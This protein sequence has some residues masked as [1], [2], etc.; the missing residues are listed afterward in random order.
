MEN[1]RKKNIA[2]HD[3]IDLMNAIKAKGEELRELIASIH[4]VVVPKLPPIEA[5]ASDTSD[6]IALTVNSDEWDP[7][8]EADYPTYWL[9]QADCSFRTALMAATRAVAQPT[10]Y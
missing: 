2:E 1:Q 10:S 8:K 3:R 4:A 7:L 6:V 5:D 9:R